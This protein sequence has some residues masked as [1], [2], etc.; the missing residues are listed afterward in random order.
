MEAALA[1]RLIDLRERIVS[2]F[3]KWINEATR[4]VSKYWAARNL[5]RK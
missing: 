4:A 1:Q 5:N 3:D 2:H